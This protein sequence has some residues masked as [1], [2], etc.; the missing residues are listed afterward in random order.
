MNCHPWLCGVALAFLLF[1]SPTSA[2]DWPQFH[3][4]RRD[5]ISRETG[6]L[7]RWPPEGPTLLFKTDGIGYGY[8]SVAVVGDRIYTAGN[9]EDDTIVTALDTDGKRLWQARNGPAYDRS[10]PGARATPTFVDGKLYHQNGDGDVVCLDAADGKPIW[11]LN[12]QRRF[13]GRNT[14]WGLSES[15]L[16]DHGRV[17]CVPGGEE[18]AVVAL[19]AETGKTVWTC[20]ATGDLPGYAAPIVFDYGGLRQIVTLLS[21]AAVGIAA[22]TG[23]LLWRYPHK[24]AYDVNINTPVY[25]DGHLALTGTWGR[26]TTLLK[27]VVNGKRCDVRQV[28]HTEELDNEHGGIVLLDGYLYGQ[29]DGN[30]RHRHWACLDF[31]TGKTMYAVEGLPGKRSGTQTYADGMLYLLSDTGTAALMPPS[32]RGFRPVSQFPLPAGGEGPVWAHPVVSNGRLYLRH[33]ELLF[34]YDV[35]RQ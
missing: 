16:V 25:H 21:G 19:S 30:H 12:V 20:P 26:G 13:V 33:G 29:A 6:L 8:A 15:L 28:W 32:P 24:V 23:R 3:G 2:D 18:F 1:A 11:S 35:R 7:K 14:R 10:Y 27:L 17:I 31:K 22:D 4:P 9:I 5:N 34:S